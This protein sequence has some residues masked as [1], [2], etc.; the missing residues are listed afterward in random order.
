MIAG[1]FVVFCAVVVV[2]YTQARKAAQQGLAEADKMW[3]SGDKA[4]A[5]T[6][7]RALV[8]SKTES[9]ALK[10]DER[11]RV[12]GRLIDFDAERGDTE[13]AKTLLGEAARA[14]VSPQVGH[15]EAVRLVAAEEARARGEVLTTEFYP[16]KSGTVQ[17]TMA[18]VYAGEGQMQSRREYRHEGDGVITCRYLKHF[19]VPGYA[20]LPLG[21]PTRVLR[22]EKDGYVEIGREIGGL[23]ETVWQPYIKVGAVA[24]DEWE[25]E[26]SPGLVTERYR[27][28][29]FESKEVPLKVG[30]SQD[31]F[32]VA[33]IEVR[34][35][36][37][38][39]GGKTFVNVEEVQFARGVGPV[40]RTTWRI[41]NGG[42]KQNWS[43][44]ITPLLK[45]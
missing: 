26:T 31:K 18:T 37:K 41:E 16:F 36:T 15:P 1:A 3:D 45:E 13:S 5:A 7:Y 27:V 17:Q 30:G 6:K 28:V 22:R 23:K 29:K 14:K 40:Y 11:G 32:M 25:R 34:N 44:N 9:A 20:E 42:R 33:F 21:K 10:D 35:T 4:G 43:E 38:L 19:M 12:Y 2:L 24:G 39:D 8:A